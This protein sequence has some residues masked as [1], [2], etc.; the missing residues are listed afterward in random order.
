MFLIC[1]N[2]RKATWSSSEISSKSPKHPES[3]DH[4]G[5]GKKITPVTTSTT[6][7]KHSETDEA[8]NNKAQED[9]IL[10]SPETPAIDSNQNTPEQ[11]TSQGP[12]PKEQQRAS[13]SLGWPHPLTSQSSM[14]W[15][16]PL[17]PAQTVVVPPLSRTSR[18]SVS[19]LT[20]EGLDRPSLTLRLTQL[21]REAK[22]IRK[23]LGLQEPP[24]ETADGE[25]EGVVTQ[26]GGM[27]PS[28]QKTETLTPK[29]FKN[30][31]TQTTATASTASTV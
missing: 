8:N 14:A 24:A 30:S 1:S 28:T 9:K 7:Q 15:S 22:R 19:P 3:T 31:E 25:V 4:S 17:P 20:V 29:A 10:N 13:N 6:K 18:Q 11:Q 26:D 5:E 12:Q 21:E 2:K 16:H 23:T 27:N